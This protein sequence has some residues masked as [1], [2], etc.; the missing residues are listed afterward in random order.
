MDSELRDRSI[1]VLASDT[2]WLTGSHAR[3][4]ITLSCVSYKNAV[5]SPVTSIG[6]CIPQ[7]SVFLLRSR[8]C[9]YSKALPKACARIVPVGRLCLTIKPQRL[10][11]EALPLA[12]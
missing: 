10:Q 5:P 4:F 8:L 6:F 3:L 11:H 7:L 1:G 2:D 12:A 9:F